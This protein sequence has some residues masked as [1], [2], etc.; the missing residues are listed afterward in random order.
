MV[1][2]VESSAEEESERRREVVNDKAAEM[3]FTRLD[4]E[5]EEEEAKRERAISNCYTQGLH[6]ESN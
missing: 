6:R 5:V 1:S 4:R 3:G 2:E